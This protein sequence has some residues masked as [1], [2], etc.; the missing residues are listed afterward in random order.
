MKASL[1]PTTWLDVVK[2]VPRP[3]AFSSDQAFGDRFE[4]HFVGLL[5]HKR[6][7]KTKS[8]SDVF[9]GSKFHEILLDF[10]TKF[11]RSEDAT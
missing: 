5:R 10:G 7:R 1:R 9:S 3:F 6:H 2:V 8:A 4:P 11:E